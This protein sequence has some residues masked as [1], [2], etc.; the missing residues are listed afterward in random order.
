MPNVADEKV[1]KWSIERGAFVGL[2]FARRRDSRFVSY[3]SPAGYLFTTSWTIVVTRDPK[4]YLCHYTYVPIY[5]PT[6]SLPP[7]HS[8]PSPLLVQLRI[9]RPILFFPSFLFFLVTTI[10]RPILFRSELEDFGG[11]RCV[12][13]SGSVDARPNGHRRRSE[14]GDLSAYP[15]YK[16]YSHTSLTL[17]RSRYSL[18]FV[19]PLNTR[20]SS[21]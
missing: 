11:S 15:I 2:D 7:I 3:S 8:I 13:R 4:T 21:S 14:G 16:K 6:T 1:T 12:L 10:P 5:S 18:V 20:R 19:L 17:P 9:D